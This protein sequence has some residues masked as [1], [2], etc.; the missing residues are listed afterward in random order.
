MWVRVSVTVK[1]SMTMSVGTLIGEMVVLRSEST[2]ASR[3]PSNCT[4]PA[5]V[6][7]E[8]AEGAVVGR[9][10]RW[11]RACR[12]NQ[13]VSHGIGDR[14]SDTRHQV[15]TNSG[16]IAVV[17]RRDVMEVGRT[18]RIKLGQR[19]RVAVQCVLAGEHATLVRHGDQSGPRR[20]RQAR[21]ADRD[22]R[23]TRTLA[24]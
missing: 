18:D 14:R 7:A 5:V 24:I 4:Y 6:A 10:G 19:L 22:P 9:W 17:P 23:T 20:G 12:I 13:I 3:R 1:L 15:E 21:A 11:R 2:R 16:G 8:E